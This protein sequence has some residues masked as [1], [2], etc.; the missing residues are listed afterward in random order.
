MGPNPGRSS[1]PGWAPTCT[2]SVRRRHA[3][4]MVIDAERACTPHATFALSTQA[5]IASSSPAPSPMSA[6][7]LMNLDSLA[8]ARPGSYVFGVAVEQ[9]DR[10]AE[11]AKDRLPRFR[12]APHAARHVEEE[13]G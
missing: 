9:L 8:G 6:F 10:V 12:R 1:W 11:D 4:A 13:R 5:R 7:R 2:R 3:V